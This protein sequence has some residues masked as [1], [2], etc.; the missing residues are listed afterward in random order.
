MS[1]E[2]A[3]AESIGR[4]VLAAIQNVSTMTTTASGPPQATSAP[5]TYNYTPGPATPTTS[6]GT[7]YRSVPFPS[8]HQ[9]TATHSRFGRKNK[10]CKHYTRDVVCL[11]FSSASTFRIPRGD[12]RANLARDGLIGKISFTSD[13]SEAQLK[14][15]M[16][17]IFRRTFA[18][19]MGQS[20][21]FE[22]LSTV[23]G[24][25]RLMKPNVSS[26][27]LWGGKE[28]ASISSA[29]C[30]YIMALISK[31]L[32][33]P[34]ELSDSD[35]ESPVGLRRRVH[36]VSPSTSESELISQGS[37]N[38][39]MQESP[40]HQ[41]ML[42]TVP[43]SQRESEARCQETE[44]STQES[45]SQGQAE[46]LRQVFPYNVAEFVPVYLEEDEALEEAIQRSLLE[47][48]DVPAV[49][50]LKSSEML[51]KEEIAGLLQAHSERVITSGTR[52]IYISRANVWTTALRVFK[53]PS[54][55]ESCDKL[56]VTFTSDEHDAVEDAA[57]LGGPRREFFRLLVKAIFQDSGAFEG[58]PNGCTPRLNML[59]LQNG[60]YRTI[61]RM[62]STIIVQGGEPPAFLSPSVVDYI[63]SG[64][65]LQV[66]VSPDD[67]GD[68]DLREN[69]NKVQHATLQDDLEKAVSCCD[70]WRYQVEGLPVVVTMANRDLF[71]KN[72]VL[73]HTVVQ[74]QSCLDQLID[75]LSHYGVL[76][77]L[78]EN[79][80]LRV[81]LNIPGED[82]GQE[83]DFVAGILKPSYSVLGSNRRAKEELIVVKFREFLQCV[84]NKELRDT[85][86]DRTLTNDEEAFLKI[87][88]PGHI[89]AF[90]TG[91]SKVPAIGFHPAPKL[92]FIHDEK[93]HL[94]IAHTC[95]NELHLFVNAKT[96]ADDDEFNYC[97]LVALMNGS[98]FSTI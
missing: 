93:K 11:P 83:A 22:Y 32:Q 21:P 76:S 69:L 97:F 20:F 37:E 28:V 19:S 14:E 94:P 85:Y 80:S 75:G 25:K 67:I 44:S 58:T 51:S 48:W 36:T 9:R 79:P 50:T 27:F 60:V 68:P 39:R 24:C 88:S 87:L 65:I 29:S 55:A 74:R 84:E 82:K 98:L 3:L 38:E 70:S 49:N 4:A 47:E 72:A 73:Y 26:S 56:Y 96:M 30:L 1:N 15:E 78:R 92:M 89:L 16:S 13:W 31:P 77:L 66:H 59:H 33:E 5:T 81:L 35:L 64:D 71:V 23:K 61:G 90:A 34:E 18:L 91:S 86:G 95:A 41:R 52:Q 62:M 2:S 46:D 42:S 45:E 57:D 7:S 6:T 54:F 12:S 43:S 10:A 63:V 8:V 40:S 17:A 53:R